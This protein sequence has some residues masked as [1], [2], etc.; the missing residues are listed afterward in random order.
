ML[1][2]VSVFFQPGLTTVCFCGNLIIMPLLPA[3]ITLDR[4]W[5]QNDKNKNKRKRQNRWK[6]E[7]WFLSLRIK[8]KKKRRHLDRYRSL[9]RFPIKTNIELMVWKKK[10]FLWYWHWFN[11]LNG[12]WHG[13]FCKIEKMLTEQKKW[14][15]GKNTKKKTKGISKQQICDSQFS[16]ICLL[17]FWVA[18]SLP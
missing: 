9:Y 12:N 11:R 7:T 15:E 10:E 13:F 2:R 5:F 1:Q 6:D 4:K 17:E 8:I 16:S 18:T 14:T 3:C